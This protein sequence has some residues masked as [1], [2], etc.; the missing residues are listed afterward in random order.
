MYTEAKV[1]EKPIRLILD[2][3]SAGIQTVII[4]AD[5]IKKTPVEEIDNFSFTIDRITILVKVLVMDAPQ[6]Q[7]NA[8]L[9]WETQKLKI[10]YQE[11][12]IIVSATSSVLEFEKEKEMPLTETY[13]ALGS[14]SNWAEETEQEI[15]E[16]SRRWKKD[17]TPC[18]TCGD[19]LLEEYNW[20]DVAIRGGVCNQTCQYALSISEKVKRR[21]SFDAAYNSAFNKL[22]HYPHNA[23]MIN[24]ATKEDVRQMKEAKYIEYTMKLA[25]FDYEN[26]IEVYHQIASYTYPTQEAQIQ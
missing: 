19:I 8:N 11:Q 26:E 1:K 13:M 25:E 17:N 3:G 6:Y 9:D 18:L 2:S 5:G 23:E 21:T 7:A 4:T 20:I 14:T 22:Y 10:S 24:R 16:E 15:F 12:H